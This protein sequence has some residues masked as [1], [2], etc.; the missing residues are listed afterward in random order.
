M[1]RGKFIVF[2]GIDGAGK[3]TQI[4]LLAAHLRAK[5]RTVFT[6]AEPTDNDTGRMLRAALSGD[7]PRTPAQMAALFVLDRVGHSCEIEAMLAGGA[8]VICDRYYYSSLAYQGSVCDY[9]WVRHMN[10][11]CPDIIHPDLCVFLD[12][13]PTAALARIQKRGEAAEIYEKEDTLTRVRE[14]FLR[15]FDTLPDRV[16][17][18]DAS[19]SADEVNAA[20]VTAVTQIYHNI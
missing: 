14:T 10:C 13:S 1:Q 12:L 20:V 17:V 18:I 5:G 3:S 16:A 11:D 4:G 2:E 7:P 6:T 9:E 19:G 15:V 8:D